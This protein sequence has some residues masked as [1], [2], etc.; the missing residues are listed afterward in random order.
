MAFNNW[1][2]TN[3]QDLNL[4]WILSKIK[5]SLTGS[6]AALAKAEAVENEVETYSQRISDAETEIDAQDQRITDVETELDDLSTEVGT[7]SQRISDAEAEADSARDIANTARETATNAQSDATSGI[8]IGQAA[9]STANTALTNAN[10]ALTIA[11]GAANSA[12]VAVDSAT[13][14]ARDAAVA[15]QLANLASDDY[16]NVSIAVYP[17]NP[18]Q[19]TKNVDE[20]LTAVTANKKIKFTL[21]DAITGETHTTYHYTIDP[22]ENTAN[23]I[24]VNVIFD[25]SVSSSLNKYVVVT[26]HKV[27][28]GGDTTYSITSTDVSFSGSGSASGAVLYDT[29]QN[30]TDAQK[31]QARNNIEADSRQL[32]LNVTDNNGVLSVDKTAAEIRAN[33]H[34]LALTFGLNE[35]VWIDSYSVKGSPPVYDIVFSVA[36]PETSS[37]SYTEYT[38][39]VYQAGY[40]PSEAEDVPSVTKRLI[41][42]NIGGGS[43]PSTSGASAGDFLRLDTNM[44][45]VWETVPS[46]ESN[47]FGGA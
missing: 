34:N 40:A 46:A 18:A 41:T 8:A 45:V 15:L 4:G 33:L 16:L 17:S 21:D 36:D 1:P 28:S 11:N 19:A 7:Y 47:S 37:V 25:V 23:D 32:I 26:F 42:H 13:D 30:L 38:V 6:A 35:G 44:N 39:N 22:V 9:Q 3:F 20:I 2:Y 14:A 43:L 31:A 10:N 27:V 29:Q 24:D 5:E 12:D